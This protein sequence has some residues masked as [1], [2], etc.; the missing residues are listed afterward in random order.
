LLPTA[1]EL[2]P[3]AAAPMPTDAELTP[4]ELPVPMAIELAVVLASLRSSMA[5]APPGA[6][7]SDTMRLS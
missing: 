2:A 7:S 3:L 4:A 6:P 5:L 1:V